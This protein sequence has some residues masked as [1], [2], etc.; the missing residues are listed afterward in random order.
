M[1]VLQLQ[2]SGANKLLLTFDKL[3]AEFQDWRAQLELLEP[4]STIEIQTRFD[5][6]GPGWLELTRVYAAQKA[7]NYPGKTILRRT[8]TLYLSFEKGNADNFVRIGPLSAE[9]GSKNP[10]GVFQP[11]TRLIVQISDQGEERMLKIVTADKS[12]KFRTLGFDVN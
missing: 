2:Q 8:D 5:Q 12:D 9:F 10:Y 11:D 7:K 4:E 1:F 3:A 6:E